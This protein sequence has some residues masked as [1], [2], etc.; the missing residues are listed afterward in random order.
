MKLI[1]NCGNKNMANN[2]NNNYSSSSSNNKIKRRKSYQKKK[3]QKL[4]NNIRINEFFINVVA[5]IR[6][7][8]E[9]I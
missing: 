1:Q 2:N 8:Q 9:K 4:N 6:Q 7:L 3:I 5:K